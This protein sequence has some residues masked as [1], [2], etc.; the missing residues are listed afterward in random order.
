MTVYLPRED[1]FLIQIAVKD[2]AK[3]SV[4]DMGTG[5]GIQALTAAT[6]RNVKKVL[7]IDISKEAVEHCKSKIHNK[8]IRFA[9]SD[10]FS[11]AKGKF[12]TIIFNPPYLPADRYKA[13][14]SV[15]GGQKGHETIERFLDDSGRHLNENGRI[16]LLFSSLTGKERVDEIISKNAFVFEQVQQKGV[17]LLETLYVY[18]VRKSD[19]L[20]KLDKLGLTD[21]KKFTKGHRGVIYTAGYKNKKVAVKV[22]RPDIEVKSLFRE[23][24]CLKK[25]QKHKIGPK[26]IFAGRDFFVYEFVDGD[27]IEK[28]IEKEKS[29]ARIKNTLKN[30]LLQC[31]QLDKLHLTKEEMQ[32]P[33]KHVIVSKKPVLIDFE[34]CKYS[35]EPKN[36]TQFCQ[37]LMSGKMSYLLKKKDVLI[38]KLKIIGLAKEYKKNFDTKS[39]NKLSALIK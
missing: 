14:V 2:Y 8:K 11:N 19:L 39:F 22:Q 37:Y 6:N 18:V 4:L 10:L 24:A 7:G 12:D 3:G 21:V 35:K 28:F 5:S 31:R 38:D 16:I 20:K 15:I 27:F 34:R 23:I 33:H 32:N 30:V 9:V 25:L 13:D 26:L 1:S 29:R 36:V 17:G